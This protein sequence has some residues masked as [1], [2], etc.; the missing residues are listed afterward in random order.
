MAL[1]EIKKLE[2]KAA[3][4]EIKRLYADD[5]AGAREAARLW[6]EQNAEPVA[7]GAAETSAFHRRKLSEADPERSSKGAAALK[8]SETQLEQVQKA[9][10]EALK[11]WRK[12]NPNKVKKLGKVYR[13][14]Q[15]LG[16]KGK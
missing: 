4:A 13:E 14:Q 12:K 16:K 7:A 5:L 9:S 2:R 8:K 11:E 1:S 10:R 15:K 6:H 3:L